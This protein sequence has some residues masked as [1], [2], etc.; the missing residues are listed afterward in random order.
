[1]IDATGISA[2]LR[3]AMD[4]VRPAGWI[5]KVG[6]GPQPM[7]FSLDPLVQKNVRLQGSFSHNWPIWERVIQLLSDGQLGIDPIIAAS[8]S[9]TNGSKPSPPC[10]L[11]RSS[12]P[13]WC[14]EIILRHSRAPE[15]R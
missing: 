4:L 15:R 13:Y 8:G 12:K 2:A 7:D 3:T 1:V 14:H 5:T 10:T 11:A 6:W 9:S